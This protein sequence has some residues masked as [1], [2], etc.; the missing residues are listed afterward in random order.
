MPSNLTHLRYEF[1]VIGWA[2][3][4][5]RAQPMP[6]MGTPAALPILRFRSVVWLALALLLCLE[7]SAAATPIPEQTGRVVDLAGLL[8]SEQHTTLENRL[9]DFQHRRGVQIAVLLVPGTRPETAEQFA[10]RV[11]EA[12]RLGRKKQD[13]GVLLLVAV[14]ERKLRIEVG[15][16]LEGALPD[17]QAKRIGSDIIAPYFAG[18]QY[19]QGIAA[20]LERIMAL[21]GQEPH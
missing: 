1:H 7:V 4:S 6:A 19:Y 21:L 3:G 11:V 9:R 13:D 14:A 12:W 2:K 18:K 20:G 16:G 15:Y 5:A 10:L 17:V 8:T